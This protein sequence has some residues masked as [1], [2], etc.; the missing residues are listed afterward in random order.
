M[1]ELK[2]LFLQMAVILADGPADGRGV[3]VRRPARGDRRDGCRYPA[4][5]VPARQNLPRNH[6]CLFPADSLGELYALS[7]LGLVLFMFLVGLEIRPDSLRG[8][9]K[10]VVLSSQASIAAPFLLGGVSPGDSI[11]ASAEAARGCRSCS[12]SVRPWAL[13]PSRCWRVSWLIAG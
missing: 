6:E 7:Q 1:P 2:L 4:G 11:R 10:T 12:S 9:A 5:S 3:P 13:R 8:S